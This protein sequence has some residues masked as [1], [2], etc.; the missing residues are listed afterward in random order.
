MTEL[1]VGMAIVAVCEMLQLGCHGYF[2]ERQ[3]IHS[4]VGIYPPPSVFVIPV[5]SVGGAV[6]IA[7]WT[8][9]VIF[10][11]SV[12]FVHVCTFQIIMIL[13]S[14]H[15]YHEGMHMA[16]VSDWMLSRH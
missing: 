6:S 2:L 12:G 5:I 13:L 14:T 4:L 7:L 10:R 16:I 9:V 3:G 1:Q 15:L 11:K 8:I